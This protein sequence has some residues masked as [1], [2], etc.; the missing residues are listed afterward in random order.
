MVAFTPNRAYPYSQ[1]TDPAD[2]PAALQALAE[3]VDAD[4]QAVI[5]SVVTR[6]F[7][8][9]SSQSPTKQ[10]FP[11][12]VVTEC[13]FDYV[14]ADTAGISNLSNYPT[15]LTPSSPGFWVVWGTVE[16]PTTAGSRT[17]DVFL[18]VNGVDITRYEQHLGDPTGSAPN[19]MSLGAM[20]F[21]N[22]TT[23]YFTMTFTPD[24]AVTDHKIGNKQMACFRVTA[25]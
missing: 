11:S 24:Q 17:K 1:P 13:T 4:M 21:M 6:P 8:K 5:N 14:D 9:V 3:A 23:D 20:S 12:D 25:T 2:V 18:R 16:V 22:G 7:A 10:L 15:R 19:R